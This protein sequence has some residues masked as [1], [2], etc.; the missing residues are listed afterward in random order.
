MVQQIL[1][2]IIFAGALAY[3]G[4]LVYRSFASRSTSCDSV[5][6]K[7]GGVDFAQIEKQLR[8]KGL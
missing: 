3:V 6:G 4:R 1:V 7:C 2:L 5:C 8:D